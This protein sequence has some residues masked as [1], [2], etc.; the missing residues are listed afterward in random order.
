MSLSSLVVF[1]K[2]YHEEKKVDKKVDISDFN[3][4]KLI[5]KGAYGKVFLVE[6]KETNIFYAM[7]QINKNQITNER[8]KRH[9]QT[10]R[11][12]L[13]KI[14]HPNILSLYYAF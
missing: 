7:K 13:G 4:L 10:E 1:G 6:H 14:K 3:V 12:I 2:I 9:A 8:W 5:G 11:M